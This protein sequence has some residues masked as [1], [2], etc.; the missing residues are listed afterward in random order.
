MGVAEFLQFRHMGVRFRKGFVQVWLLRQG[1]RRDEDFLFKQ[2]CDE[3]F[4]IF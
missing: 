2:R 1:R 3:L 4:Q